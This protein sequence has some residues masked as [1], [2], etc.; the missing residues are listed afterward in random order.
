MCLLPNNSIAVADQDLGVFV[1]NINGQLRKNF[2]QLAGS[3]SLCYNN[4]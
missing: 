3:G 2:N 1:F 4:V